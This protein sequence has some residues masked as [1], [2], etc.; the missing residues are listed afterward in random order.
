MAVLERVERQVATSLDVGVSMTPRQIG[1]R[2]FV[3]AERDHPAGNHEDKNTRAA[4]DG[5]PRRVPSDDSGDD[6]DRNYAEEDRARPN[7]RPCCSGSHL[8]NNQVLS[9]R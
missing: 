7:R 3:Q 6:S 8:T 4:R 2:E 5:T 1:M 9:C